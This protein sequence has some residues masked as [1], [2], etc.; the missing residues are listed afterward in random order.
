MNL[1]SFNFA[2]NM[3]MWSYL[4]TG[5]EWYLID[6]SLGCLAAGRGK[7]VDDGLRA[8]ARNV[9]FSGQAS[10]AKSYY[11]VDVLAKVFADF[12]SPNPGGT[13]F[14]LAGLQKNPRVVLIDE[15]SPEKL[16][17]CFH[18]ESY[19]EITARTSVPIAQGENRGADE[20]PHF[21][22]QRTSFFGTMPWPQ[23]EVFP[24]PAATKTWSF[25]K[26]SSERYQSARRHTVVHL[27]FV[28]PAAEAPAVCPR[29]YCALLGQRLRDL[30]AQPVRKGGAAEAWIE[31]VRNSLRADGGG[32]AP[33]AP[34]RRKIEK[35]DEL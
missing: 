22:S 5:C 27:P 1:E 13:N 7:P 25:E 34:K 21:D 29:G 23:Q 32:A 28:F 17:M 18:W 31:R 16:D 4:H 6:V 9:F 15:F 20:V 11:S 19:K 2:Q 14:K 3:L 12:W 10:A 26:I 35:E 33:V 8:L 24:G 30:R